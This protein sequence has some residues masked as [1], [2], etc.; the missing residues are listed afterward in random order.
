MK[1]KPK[2]EGIEEKLSRYRKVTLK[3]ISELEFAQKISAKN[4]KIAQ[5]FLQNA[6][7]YFEDSLYF[8][9]QGDKA[10]ALAAV[11]YAHA[12]LDAGVTADFFKSFHYH[13]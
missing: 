10:R 2:I 13:L 6:K 12:W 4:R 5:E 1:K 11:S 9:A 7:C 8:E 3:V